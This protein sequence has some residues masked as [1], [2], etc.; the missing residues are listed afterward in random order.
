MLSYLVNRKDLLNKVKLLMDTTSMEN[1][2]KT[3]FEISRPIPI[4]VVTKTMS[5][6]GDIILLYSQCLYLVDT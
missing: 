4:R 5:L 6:S 2:G 1:W 3:R